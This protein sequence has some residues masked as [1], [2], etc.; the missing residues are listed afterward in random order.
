[1]NASESC[2]RHP[3]RRAGVTCQRCGSRI[4]P[5]CMRSAS[6]GF[7]CPSC[8][9]G[10]PIEAKNRR[11][12]RR[13]SG[14]PEATRAIIGLNALAFLWS[15]INGGSLSGAGGDTTLD[16]GLLGFGRTRVDGLMTDIGVAEG[17]WWRL[18]SSA[19]LH[20]GILH[21][22]F[23]MYLLWMLG[24]Q[25]EQL[26]GRSRFVGLYVGSLAAGSLG[27]MLMDPT[28]LTVGASGAVFGLMAA[29][30]VHQQRR[31]ISPWRSGI[32]GLVLLNVFFTFGRPGI[33]IGG[34]L[35]GLLGGAFLAWA[36]DEMDKKQVSRQRSTLVVAAFTVLCLV[37][38]VWAANRWYDPVF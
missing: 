4:C 5:D 20:A 27:V 9:A 36:L 28:A 6:V 37:A 24:R 31:G 16:F 25:L 34:H 29:M 14:D 11:R 13:A 1:M 23:N 26:H 22:V 12:V 30:F 2:D 19:F 10:S 17:E 32:G 35:G 8:A 15:L 7:H 21:I 18:V 38:S 3:D 33:S